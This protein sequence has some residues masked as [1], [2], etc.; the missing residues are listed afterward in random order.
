M[1]YMHTHSHKEYRIMDT[2]DNS[3]AD[4]PCWAVNFRPHYIST[5][6]IP[7]NKSQ[8]LVKLYIIQKLAKNIFKVYFGNVKDSPRKSPLSRTESTPVPLDSLL[9]IVKPF[10]PT[11]GP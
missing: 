9:I 7:K 11:I 8:C 5:F 4:L 10:T 2:Q 1:T 6:T 3:I